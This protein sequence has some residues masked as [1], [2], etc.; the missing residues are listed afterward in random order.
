LFQATKQEAGSMAD[1]FL[2]TSRESHL[3]R[4]SARVQV[5]R[6]KKNLSEEEIYWEKISNDARAFNS[7]IYFRREDLN[8]ENAQGKPRKK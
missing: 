7:P 8:S 3:K 2:C 6:K 5:S 4:K 1:C